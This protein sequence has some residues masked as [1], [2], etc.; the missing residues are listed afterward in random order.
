MSDDPAMASE[1]QITI[2]LKEETGGTRITL[3]HEGIPERIS[4]EDNERG[5]E[6]SLDN[7]ARLVERHNVA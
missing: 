7:L 1:M 6:A 3:Q 4:V 5:S 2:T